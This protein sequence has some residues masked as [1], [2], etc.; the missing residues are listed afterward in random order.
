[1]IGGAAADDVQTWQ[2]I[3]EAPKALVALI[4]DAQ[5]S[6]ILVCGWLTWTASVRK[7][8]GNGHT[9]SDRPSLNEFR[10]NPD[11]SGQSPGSVDIWSRFQIR[12]KEAP[13]FQGIVLGLKKGEAPR[14][15]KD[16]NYYRCQPNSKVQ[17]LSPPALARRQPGAPW[18]VAIP[19]TTCNPPRIKVETSATWA[20]VG[21]LRR[22]GSYYQRIPRCVGLG[23]R[24][25]PRVRA[26]R[27]HIHTEAR[28]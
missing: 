28:R 20:L 25:P 2:W 4:A 21:R 9:G 26:L 27:M 16:P 1:M 14:S 8:M 18:R 11:L 7:L 10:Y 6:F 13:D 23:N 17:P 15:H 3:C 24:N 22:V 5:N 12:R 19:V